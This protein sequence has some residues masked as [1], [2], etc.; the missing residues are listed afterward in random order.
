MANVENNALNNTIVEVKNYVDDPDNLY[1]VLRAG[2]LT[3][4]LETPFV[5]FV[6]AKTM[7]YPSF[8][9]NSTDLPDYSKTNGYSRVDV[10]YE[11]TEVTVSQDKGYQI[12]VDAEDLENGHLTSIAIINN[13]V[14]QMEIPSIDKYRLNKLATESGV[15]TISTVDLTTQDA[16]ELYDTAI[17]SLVD[18]EIPKEGTILYCTPDFYTKLKQ[19]DNVRRSINV[20][21]NNGVINREIIMIDGVTKVMEVPSSRMPSNTKFILVQPLAQ[22]SGIKRN[23]S[24]VIPEPE[25]FDGILINRRLVHDT[26]VLK[27]R[28]KGVYV[29]KT[30]AE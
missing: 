12:A 20:Q 17:A 26:F 8:P 29:G 7:S 5:Q 25:D 28:L 18:N 30:A 21:T 1:G 15:T 19:S 24:V 6:G 3:S 4:D 16:L 2:L 27:T 13:Q 14:R 22:I 10:N 9:L 23:K 11:R